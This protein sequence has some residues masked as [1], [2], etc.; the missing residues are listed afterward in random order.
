MS[1]L[2]RRGADPSARTKI[3]DHATSLE[4]AVRLNH[5]RGAEALRSA[6]AGS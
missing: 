5:L 1:I 6:G 3:D 2:K 4:E